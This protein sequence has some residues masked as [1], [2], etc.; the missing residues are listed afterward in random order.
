VA[1][2]GGGVLHSLGRHAGVREQPWLQSPMER[3]SS[4]ELHLPQRERGRGVRGSSRRLA[5]CADLSHSDAVDAAVGPFSSVTDHCALTSTGEVVC[6]GNDRLLPLPSGTFTAIECRGSCCGI[7]AD[8]TVECWGYGVDPHPFGSEQFTAILLSGV[9]KC[10][11][12][13]DGTIRCEG[14]LDICAYPPPCRPLHWPHEPRSR[15][16]RAGRGFHRGLLGV[17]RALACHRCNSWSRESPSRQSGIFV[18]R[19]H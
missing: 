15:D 10:G 8:Q 18:E 2:V 9:S 5:G 17:L 19:V 1:P 11:I 3:T 13:V 6:W 12:R 4:W 16:V 14:A 7:R